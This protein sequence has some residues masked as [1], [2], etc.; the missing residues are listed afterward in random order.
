MAKTTGKISGNI[1]MVYMDNVLVGC[2]TDNGF[3]LTNETIESSCKTGDN[4]PPRTY[5]PGVQDWTLD[6]TLMVRFDDS[7]QYS[8][9]AAAAKNA[10]THT[11]KIAT[12][13]SDDPYWQGQGFISSF[14]ETA[15]QGSMLTA[16]VTVSPKGEL[17]LLNT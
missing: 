3:T 12:S 5:E 8:A 6:F 11:W 1:R 17:F 14:G 9:V 7:N 10:T 4:P 13:N 16:P 15:P 2:T